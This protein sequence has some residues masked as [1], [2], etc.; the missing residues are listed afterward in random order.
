[1]NIKL[2]N[3]IVTYLKVAPL[4]TAL[5]LTVVPYVQTAAQTRRICN[6]KVYFTPCPDP[7]L[8]WYGDGGRSFAE[9]SPR[10]QFRNGGATQNNAVKILNQGFK[11]VDGVMGLWTGLV[12]G[13]GK[14][15]LHLKILRAGRLETIRY[16]GTVV[17]AKG[18]KPTPFFFK[19]ALP[20]GAGWSWQIAASLKS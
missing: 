3:N 18:E 8:P 19:S 12:S 6:G 13:T 2:L 20:E 17:Q 1:M 7:E 9:S 10:A 15:A 16:I 14:I 11:K 5:L 4:L